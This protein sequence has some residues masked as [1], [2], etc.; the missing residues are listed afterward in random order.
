MESEWEFCATNGGINRFPWGDSE[1][2]NKKANINYEH[3][4]S[5]TVDNY[6]KGDNKWG[7]SN[8]IGNVWEWTD[9]GSDVISAVR[10]GAWN[11]APSLARVSTRLELA[12]DFRSNYIGFRVT[13]E[14]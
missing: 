13:R 4:W 8:L 12:S 7:V 6:S 2:D 14:R 1:P 10:G 9:S 5:L 3:N 11:F